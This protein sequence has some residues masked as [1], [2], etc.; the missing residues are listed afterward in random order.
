MHKTEV[1]TDQKHVCEV[2]YPSFKQRADQEELEGI[3][4]ATSLLEAAVQH[5]IKEVLRFKSESMKLK[6]EILGLGD[7][8]ERYQA[9][10]GQ[11]KIN[12]LLS[13]AKRLVRIIGSCQG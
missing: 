3:V 6:K 2:F 1:I 7:S 11:I 8:L 9:S 4:R 5:Q 10:L 12:R 13:K